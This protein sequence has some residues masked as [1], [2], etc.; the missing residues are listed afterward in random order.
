VFRVTLTGNALLAAPTNASDGQ[1]LRW[2]FIQ[3]ATGERELT[4]AAAFAL[5]E[6]MS[7]PLELSFDPNVIDVLEAAYD[8]QTTKWFVLNF[9]RG[10]T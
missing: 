8:A 10:Y 3:D 7:S 1:V 4:L 5:P 2:Y 9:Q 6:S